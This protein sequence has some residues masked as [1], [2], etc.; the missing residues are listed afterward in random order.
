MHWLSP[1]CLQIVLPSP[2]PVTVVSSKP[3]WLQWL[4]Y[5]APLFSIVTALASLYV[6]MAVYKFTQRKND[7]DRNLK[8]FQELVVTTNKETLVNFFKNLRQIGFA[9]PLVAD[10][11]ED[12]R[13]ST[14]DKIK[15]ERNAFMTNFVDLIQPIAPIVHKE[16]KDATDGLVDVLTHAFDNE[17]LKWNVDAVRQREFG[18][19]I[20]Q[21]QGLIFKAIFKYT[22]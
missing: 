2:L 13:I 19:K 15:A 14:M 1:F 5:L 10:L 4:V 16:V 18:D 17:E 20:S 7:R 8:W 6:A 12:E 9:I 22:G 21:A 11:P 3:Q